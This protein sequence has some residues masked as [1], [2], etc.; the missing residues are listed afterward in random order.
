MV[1]RAR[2]PWDPP[3]Q[4][5]T[6]DPSSAPDPTIP[7]SPH[8][9]TDIQPADPASAPKPPGLVGPDSDSDS[10]SDEPTI[11]I[12]GDEYT[13]DGTRWRVWGRTAVSYTSPRP[14]D[15]P[16][17]PTS[18]V[19]PHGLI[20]IARANP[21]ATRLDR[22]VQNTRRYPIRPAAA[23]ARSSRLISCPR[24]T[25]ATSSLQPSASDNTSRYPSATLHGTTTASPTL[26]SRGIRLQIG[27]YTAR[28]QTIA[29][30][31]GL[32]AVIEFIE[33]NDAITPLAVRRY[34]HKISAR[35]L[36]QEE[37]VRRGGVER[38]AE[39][40]CCLG[41][42]WLGGEECSMVVFIKMMEKRV[43]RRRKW[44]DRFTWK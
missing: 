9:Y 19:E 33:R 40:G 39:M 35:D 18:L 28:I 3:P 12:T 21:A 20:G 23:A 10:D 11:T 36:E 15:L 26:L 22:R 41:V 5:L 32:R 25:L 38:E 31:E 14:K 27:V 43:G 44:I 8:F 30:P 16:M 17:P 29:T 37:Y 1:S 2:N 7:L 4:P 34:Y 13:D 24:S 6:T 42:S